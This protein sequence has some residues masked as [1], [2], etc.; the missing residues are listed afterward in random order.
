MRLFVLIIL[1]GLIAAG[2]SWTPERDNPKDPASSFYIEPPQANRAPRVEQ[3][4]ATTHIQIANDD[5]Y[6]TEIAAI[7]SDPDN[8]LQYDRVSAV[9]GEIALGYMSFDGERGLFVLEFSENDLPG[10]RWPE[11][12]GL[13]TIRV[14]AVDDSGAVGSGWAVY[15]VPDSQPIP[16]VRYPPTNEVPVYTFQPWLSWHSWGTPTDGHTYSVRVNL[17]EQLM[18]DTTGLPAT[19]DSVR[20]TRT[21]LS[22]AE[23]PSRHYSWYLTVIDARGDTRTSRPGLF[24]CFDDTSGT[25]LSFTDTPWDNL[26]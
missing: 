11:D 20:V 16:S 12:L 23:D 22:S 18:W 13:D 4:Q 24:S 21:L 5:F 17:Y 6:A 26:P 15:Y 7:L 14:T 3:V 2:C 10:V 9:I 25:H 1:G 8:N 19:Q